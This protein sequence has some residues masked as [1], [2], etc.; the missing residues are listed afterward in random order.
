VVASP[1]PPRAGRPGSG[2]SGRRPIAPVRLV[3]LLGLLALLG[4]AAWRLGPRAWDAGNEL[5]GQGPVNPNE[6]PARGPGRDP[7]LEIPDVAPERVDV[8]R[9]HRKVLE[10]M[11]GATWICPWAIP[12]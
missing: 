12:P 3:G 6:L 4:V 11:A 8:V 7:E 5:L 9:Q 1:K 10:E 2:S